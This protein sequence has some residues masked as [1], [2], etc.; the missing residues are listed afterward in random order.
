MGLDGITIDELSAPDWADRVFQC[1]DACFPDLEAHGKIG[2][3]LDAKLGTWI[4]HV[5]GARLGPERK[6]RSWQLLVNTMLTRVS[7]KPSVPPFPTCP[8]RK[9]LCLW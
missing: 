4:P 3:S 2:E 1:L 5:E 6:A 7:L 8:R 9:S